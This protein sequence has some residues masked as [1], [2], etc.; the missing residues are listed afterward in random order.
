MLPSV[1]PCQKRQVP[2]S[3]LLAAALGCAAA[4]LLGSATAGQL[5]Y[6]EDQAPAIVNPLFTTSMAETR[7]SELLFQALY[8]DDHTLASVPQLAE[9]GELSTDRLHMTVRLRENVTWQDGTPFTAK[10]VVF[11]VK[12]MKDPA[13]AST[14]A[15]RA[16][17]I[18]D[19]REV[20]THAVQFDF[21]RPELRPEDKLTFKILPASAFQT[22][23]V[24]RTDAFR[25]NPIGTGPWSLVKFN[26]DNSVSFSANAGYHGADGVDDVGISQ[27]T[28]KEVADKNYQAKLLLYESI[29]ALV[30]VLPRDLAMLQSNRKVELYPYQTNSWWYAGFNLAR[31]PFSDPKV[32]QAITEMLDVPNMLAPIG[33]GDLIT[34]PYVPSS[35]FYNHETKPWPHDPDAASALLLSAGYQRDPD[36]WYKAG[37]KLTITVSAHRAL[38]SAQEVTINLQS[39]LQAQGIDVTIDFLDEAA[40]RQQVWTDRNYDVVLSQWTFD[41]NEDIRE[42]FHSTGS[43]N[44]MGLKDVEVDRLLDAARDAGDPLGRK[45]ALRQ[46]HQRIHD[47]LPMVF[48]W[49]LDSYAALSTKV[50]AV[51]VHPF[52]FFTW[53][54]EW[55]MQ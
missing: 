3:T 40:W 4:S 42:Q 14:E 43:R 38:E 55:Q 53:A 50:K 44:L 16:Q 5:R 23:P 33:T 28:L 18:T 9:S 20:G 36:G 25:K 52:A 2:S 45:T 17:F 22:L 15:G 31:A 6:A 1:P 34:G 41:R 27:I 51:G 37:R 19:C 8:A 26:D 29:D 10:D 48:L 32:R 7:V 54:S 24:K 39:Q 12:A 49:T 21:V 13:T 47:D 46:A 35:P 30:R 11:T